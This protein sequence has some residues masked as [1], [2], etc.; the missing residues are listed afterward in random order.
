MYR[1][2]Q[3][4]PLKNRIGLLWKL[5]LGCFVLAGLTGF[6]YRLGMVGWLPA[7]IDLSLESVRHAHSHLMFFSWAV[8]VPLYF[9]LRR[10]WRELGAN[11]PNILMVRTAKASLFLGVAAYPFFLLYGYRP[12]PLGGMEFPV[13]VML[14]G[15]VM[16]CW[17]GFMIGYWKER[18]RITDSLSMIFYDSALVML[19]VCSL[20][21]WGVAAVQFSG[22]TNPLFGKALTHFFL[23][24]FTEGFVMM[25]LLGILYEQLNISMEEAEITPGLLVGFILFGAPL[26]FPYGISEGLLSP[27]L[28]MVARAGGLLA[29]IGLGLNIYVLLKRSG[30]VADGYWKIVL[31]LLAAKGLAQLLASILPSSFWLSEHG[32]RIFYLHLL[33]LGAFTLALFRSLHRELEAPKGL[34]P[35]YISVLLVLASL[36]LLTPIWPQSWFAAWQFYM[37]VFLA[38]LPPLAGLYY[39]A[40]VLTVNQRSQTHG[41]N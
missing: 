9:I 35:L 27:N 19:F 29:T 21:A 12:V 34:T 25:A 26:T 1:S 24:T 15:L 38:V 40:V 22:L 5:P 4:K 13:S 7:A 3:P 32:L 33:L 39:L 2:D 41:H 17:Y 37:V 16:L 28:L 6:L 10:V 11:E 31:A 30:S 18:K 14:S 36:V 8:P 20:G 23:A